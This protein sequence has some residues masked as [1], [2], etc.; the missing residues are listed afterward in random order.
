[1]FPVTGIVN[2]L[3]PT[4]SLPVKR[5]LSREVNKAMPMSKKSSLMA[6]LYVKMTLLESSFSI[7]GKKPR[8]LSI[9]IQFLVGRLFRLI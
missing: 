1:M 7:K 3:G 2:T 4:K 8:S 6:M 5:C 9:K